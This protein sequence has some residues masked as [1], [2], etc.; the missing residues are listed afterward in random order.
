MKTLRERK[1]FIGESGI[2]KNNEINCKVNVRENVLA[3]RTNWIVEANLSREG[4]DA[5]S[6]ILEA[7]FSL[8][9]LRLK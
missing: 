9:G 2:K 4:V 5:S 7:K 3:A 6:C 8:A 1:H